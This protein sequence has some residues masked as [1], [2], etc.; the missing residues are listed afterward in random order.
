MPDRRRHR[1]AHPRDEESFAPEALPTLRTA[2]ADYRWLLARDYPPT[3]SLAL[4]GNRYQLRERQRQAVQRASVAAATATAR[5]AR[6][7]PPQWVGGRTVRVDGYNVLL[8]VE[9][10]LG[11]GVVLRCADGV[12]RDM[13]S[14]RGHYRR[15]EETRRALVLLG[16]FLADH[17]AAAVAWYLDRP[18]SNSGRLKTLMESTAADRGWPWNVELVASP[19]RLLQ[20]SDD[21][22][23]TADG[24]ILDAGG[25]WLD[26]ARLVI[27][28][29]V[30]EAWIVDLGRGGDEGGGSG[31]TDA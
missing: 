6:R 11:G 21:I 29:D 14:M 17:G 8:T 26:L 16:G 3:A 25:P 9:T 31:S 18:I 4:V 13:A 1:G 10:A 22:V 28:R 7:L 19:D 23:A 30:P 2:A 12:C 15:V 24:G 20:E 27:E 5:L